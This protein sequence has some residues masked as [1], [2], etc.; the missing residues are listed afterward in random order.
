[1]QE[2]SSPGNTRF[3]L[4][5]IAIALIAVA[6]SILAGIY[7]RPT[8]LK[9]DE[10]YYFAL[11]KGIAGGVYDD[12]YIIR[13]PLYPLFLGAIIRIWA[14]GFTPIL[15]IQAVI[16][17][18]LVAQVSYMGRRYA[19]ST[20]GL[21]AGALLAVYPFLIWIHTRFLNEALYLPLFLLSFYMVDRALKTERRGDTF[22]AGLCCGLAALARATS[23][24][25]T[26][27]IAV[28]LVVRKSKS[29][30][31]SGRNLANA[32]LLLVALFIAVS[33]WTIRNA[34]V[35][36]TFMPIGNEAAYNL[37]FIVSG[38]NLSEATDQW[39]SWGSQAERQE[40][41][42]R[43]WRDYV[44]ANPGFHIKRMVSR[45]PR[46]FNPQEQ[47]SAKGLAL[48]TEGAGARRH[49]TLGPVLDVLTPLMFV[50]LMAGG[51]IGL[52]AL[53]DDLHRRMLALITVL[54]FVLLYAPTIMKARYF[55]PVACLLSI[56]AA[57][58]ITTVFRKARCRSQKIAE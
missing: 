42:L 40:E 8:G 17:G 50:I 28:W 6:I 57:R 46:I 24:F 47:R 43:R 35:H 31:F 14:T 7:T 23:F 55:L 15:L 56:Y 2:T 54:Y 39:L 52:A 20:T 48:V 45:L 37:W 4:I 29:G 19:S 10:K 21:I 53:R 51:L 3:W 49:G 1:M 11:A 33:P 36:G 18:G 13:P 32:F 25:L 12:G 30:R 38:V 5:N 22:M 26:F 34:T 41:G 16:R 9:F 27:V 58:L 44:I